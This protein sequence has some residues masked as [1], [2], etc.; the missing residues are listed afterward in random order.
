MRRAQSSTAP[1]R[2]VEEW[3]ATASPLRA[4]RIGSARQYLVRSPTAVTRGRAGV[5]ERREGLF[6]APSHHRETVGSSR[7]AVPVGR[8][9]P[10]GPIGRAGQ[11]SIDSKESNSAGTQGTVTLPLSP[12]VCR[13]RRIPLLERVRGRFRKPGP[14]DRIVENK[15]W[16][17]PD[18]DGSATS[19][20][21]HTREAYRRLRELIVRGRL[22]PGTRIVEAE[23]AQRFGVSRTPIRSALVK[24]RQEGYVT[25]LNDRH[26]ARLS[27]A[28]LTSEDAKELWAVVAALEG[29][30]VRKVAEADADA[31]RRTAD[32]LR[33]TNGALLELAAEVDP[34]P[35]RIFD[36]DSAFHRTFVTAGAGPRLRA[37]HESI[38]PQTERYF[39]LYTSSIVDRIAVSVAEHERIVA[40]IEAGDPDAAAL[41]VESNWRNGVSRLVAA[42]ETL[43]ER[44]SW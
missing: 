30:A 17:S 29:L 8:A 15:R 1:R 28:A 14:T 42:I 2:A 3:S 31:R 44:G 38:K 25:A 7:D 36:L 23:L 33:S 12:G 37:L 6:E 39:R 40:A 18:G 21:D 24:L 16:H 13:F 11:N 4:W 27:V 32:S 22:A 43:G 35:N 41:A 9:H 20:I 19:K 10:A 34:D 5:P 26:R